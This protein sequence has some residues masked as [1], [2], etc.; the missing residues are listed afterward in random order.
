MQK[1]FHD[2]IG[3]EKS[4]PPTF[5]GPVN[6][7]DKILIGEKIILILCVHMRIHKEKCSLSKWPGDWGDYT[8]LG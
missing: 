6:Q 8:I 4:S 7:I 1:I 5:L 2:S 3:Q